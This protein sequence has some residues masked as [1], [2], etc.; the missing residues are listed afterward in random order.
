MHNDASKAMG[1]ARSKGYI[2][3]Y[4]NRREW[5]VRLWG[6]VEIKLYWYMF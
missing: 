3:V 1:E 6:N 5:Q 4:M 2:H